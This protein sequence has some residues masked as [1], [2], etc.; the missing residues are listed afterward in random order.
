MKVTLL[1][2]FLMELALC[3]EL[4]SSIKVNLK[5]DFSKEKATCKTIRTRFHL[6]ATTM[7]ERKKEKD[8]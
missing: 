3:K 6:R 1:K 7:M 2:D 8:R 4:S 5:V